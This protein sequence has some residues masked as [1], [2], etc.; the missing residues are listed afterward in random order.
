[1]VNYDL[2]KSLANPWNLLIGGQYPFEPHW[3]D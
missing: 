2:D 1:V 3:W